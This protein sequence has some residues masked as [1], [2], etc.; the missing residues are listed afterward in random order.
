[1]QDDAVASEDVAMHIL[2]RKFLKASGDDVVRH[3]TALQNLIKV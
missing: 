2:K 3:Q 1:M